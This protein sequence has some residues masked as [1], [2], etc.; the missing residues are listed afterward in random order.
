VSP[1]SCLESDDDAA[2]DDPGAVVDGFL[3]VSGGDPASLFES[4]E[5]AFDDVAALVGLRVEGVG[6][7]AGAA[8][9]L[10]VGGWSARLGMVT[11][12]AWRA[13]VWR[14]AAEE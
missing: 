8:S 12:N 2:R 10:V 11:V 6:A 1:E 5:A 13:S 9:A 7:S 3:V 14:L 4:V